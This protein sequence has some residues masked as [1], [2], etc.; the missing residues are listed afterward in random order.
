MLSDSRDGA[1]IVLDARL[2]SGYPGGVEQVA[3]GMAYGMSALEGAERYVFMAYE[4][5]TDW[6][7]PYVSGPCSIVEVPAPVDSSQGV[8]GWLA[9]S[10]PWLAALRRRIIKSLHQDAFGPV[11]LA[12]SDGTAER[13]DANV[14]HF[15]TQ[16]GFR[17][18][19]PSIYHPHDLQ[20]RHLPEFFTPQEVAQRDRSWRELCEQAR[21][22][23]VTSRWGKADVAAQYGIDPAKIAVVHLAPAIAAYSDPTPEECRLVREKWGLPS[24]FALYPAQTWAHKNH[25]R[26]IGA[27]GLLRDQGVDVQLICT[28]RQNDH[29][30]AIQR[31][32]LVR[33]LDD[34]VRFL[35]FVPGEELRALFRLATCLIMPTLF[36]AAGGFG[37]IAEAFVSGVPV[38]CSNVTSLPEEVGDAAITFD[39]YDESQIADALRRV[40]QDAALRAELVAKGRARVARYSWEKTAK[41]FRAYYRLLAGATLTQ[42]D[43]ALMVEPTDY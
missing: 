14:I 7:R 27:I 24:A 6:L 30:P 37:P 31:E 17:T 10:L 42:E 5:S 21:I 26:L 39:P 2:E 43:D 22:V 28:G 12:E 11:A 8:R 3:I 34:R 9:R 23:S 15:L 29:F 19:I 32:L 36:E 4:G 13:L 18:E 35:G 1:L 33:G 25:I 20:H 38:A 41:V 16:N 40:W